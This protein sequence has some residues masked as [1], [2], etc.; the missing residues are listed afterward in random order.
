MPAPADTLHLP[1]EL[2]GETLAAAL[3]AWQGCPWGKARQ[4]IE[5]RHV[6]VNGNLCVNESRRLKAG[7]VLRFFKHALP[8]PVREVDV[9]IAYLDEDLVVV[10]KPAGVTTLRHRAEEGWSEQRKQRQPTL[11]ELL[12]RLIARELGWKLPDDEPRDARS[13][14]RSERERKARARRLPQVRAVHRLDRDTSGVMLFARTPEAE[15]K[16]IAMFKRHDVRRTYLA[17]VQGR[18]EA[19]T[20]ESWLVRDRGDGLRGSSPL[21]E[22]AEGALRAVTHMRPIEL[23]P[24]HTIVQC[25]LETGRTHQIRIHLS[26]L[27]HPL[28]GEGVYT[29]ALGG[30]EREDV[31][32]APR[33]ALHAAEI[34]FHHPISG[35]WLLFRMP[36]PRDLA[37]WVLALRKR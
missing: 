26:E 4:L 31:S 36:L 33:Q 7:D 18:L 21:G 13:R 19:Q 25:R 20:I 30:P 27:G 12:P 34:G 17:V 32:Q 8:P 3:R 35:E 14:G 22:K 28:C 2:A 24:E 16:L 9:R 1:P 29:H 15:Q 23:L 5:R 11:E 6:Q 10:E 37:Q